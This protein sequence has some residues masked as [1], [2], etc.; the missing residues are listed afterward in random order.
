MLVVRIVPVVPSLRVPG[1]RL[2]MLVG[3]M[4]GMFVMIV[5]APGCHF[6]V[7]VMSM[8]HELGPFP[9]LAG[10]KSNGL[11]RCTRDQPVTEGVPVFGIGATSPGIPLPRGRW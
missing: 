10:A 3:V 6:R 2:V 7:G 4:G 11:A 9:S 1:G 5:P 8:C